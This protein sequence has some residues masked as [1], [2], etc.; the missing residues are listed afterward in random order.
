M[1]IFAN[2]L[3]QFHQI[4]ENDE[5]WGEG[6]TDWVS[7]KEAKPQFIGHKQPRVPLNKNYYSLDNYESIKWQVEL[8]RKYGIA[9]FGIY[10]YWFHKGLNLLTKPAEIILQN[11]DLDIE[12]FF[13]WDNK[14]WKRTWSALTGGASWTA[15]TSKETKV[16]AELVYGSEDEWKAHFEFLLPFFKDSRYVKFNGK[17]IF[18]LFHTFKE[19]ERLKRIEEYWNKLAIENDLKGIEF[20]SRADYKQKQFDSSFIYTP[21]APV[22]VLDYFEQK[23]KRILWKET[24][25]TTVSGLFLTSDIRS[26]TPWRT[27]RTLLFHMENA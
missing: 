24:N 12:F 8:A 13:I 26:G 1:K 20:V 4:P 27:C 19:F 3:P 5:F 9:G 2:Y 23:L 17:P 11:K 25:G 6:F 16:L 18:A 7:C 22:T 15:E 21:F 10:H 14:S